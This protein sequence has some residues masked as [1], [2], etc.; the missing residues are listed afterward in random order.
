MTYGT[1]EQFLHYFGLRSLDDLPAADELRRWTA[2]PSA[3]ATPELGL[4]TSPPAPLTTTTGN[5]SAPT[6]TEHNPSLTSPPVEVPPAP[7]G[8]PDQPPSTPTA[9][10]PTWPA[11]QGPC[12]PLRHRTTVAPSPGQSLTSPHLQTSRPGPTPIPI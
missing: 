6:N 1:T 3:G 9:H 7:P 12:P 5:G 2:P 10:G 11:G 4:A 8:Q